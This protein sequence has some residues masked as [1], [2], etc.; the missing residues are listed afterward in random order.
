MFQLS[1]KEEKGEELEKYLSS[2]YWAT[3]ILSEQEQ[4][5]IRECFIN[6]ICQDELANLLGFT[7][8]DDHEFRRLRKSAIFKFADFMDLVVHKK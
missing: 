5:Y 3:S 4:A 8:R 1:A 6:Q 7:S 2:Y